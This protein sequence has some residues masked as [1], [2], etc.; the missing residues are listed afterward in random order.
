[1]P[2]RPEPILIAARRWLEI[3]PQSGEA[4]ARAMFT[5]VEKY[6][7]LT[8]TQYE[9]ALEWLRSAALLEDL[10]AAA[11]A[12]H[13]VLMAAIETSDAPWLPNA[14]E[15]D[16]DPR[17]LPD[18]VLAAAEAL[19]IDAAAASGYVRTAWGKVDQVMRDQ[20]G[21][22]GEHAL[23]ELL[24]AHTS[25]R[26]EHV[27][28]WSDGLGF[29]IAVSSGD[30]V[31]HLEVKSTTR[32]QRLTLYLSRNEYRASQRD[33]AWRLIV[34]R[35]DREDLSLQSVATVPT[36]WLA[37]Q[38][39]LDV[40]GFGSWESC[41]VDVPPGFLEPGLSTLDPVFGDNIDQVRHLFR[42]SLQA[43]APTGEATGKDASHDDSPM[44]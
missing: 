22:A 44:G 41:R 33:P 12:N 35:L 37:A 3:L 17:L 25:A 31:G 43:S 24:N 14:D 39:P 32:Q 36:D 16:D 34:L 6:S 5:N 1:M 10:H 30:V 27:S 23:V 20:V 29:D 7:D 2:I 42:W 11:P 9:S 13:R 26:V 8:S 28:L 38:M 19:E 15:F 18:E 4:R 40:H 21:S